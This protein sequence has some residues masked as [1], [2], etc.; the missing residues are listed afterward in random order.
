MR[1]SSDHILTSHVG[2]LP[3]PHSVWQG[4]D[5]GREYV[6]AAASHRTILSLSFGEGMA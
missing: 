5:V 3:G 6:I 4:A 1:R 2:A